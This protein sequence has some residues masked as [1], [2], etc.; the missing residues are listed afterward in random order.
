MF[1]F[2]EALRSTKNGKQKYTNN[3]TIISV[4]NDVYIYRDFEQ[5]KKMVN[6]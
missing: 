6:K 5:H 2:I 1:T 3:T 4:N